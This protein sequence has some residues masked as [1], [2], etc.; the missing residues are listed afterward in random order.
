MGDPSDEMWWRAPKGQAHDWCF[1]QVRR[2]EMLQSDIYERFHKLEVLYDPL[3][4]LVTDS[5]QNRRGAVQENAIATNVDTIAATIATA[6]VDARFG[7]EGADWQ[8]QRRAIHLQ[9]YTEELKIKLEVLRYCRGGFKEGAKKGNGLV[10]VEEMFGAPH[11]RQVMVEN[12][13]IDMWET[14]DN[15]PAT[16]MHEW[17]SCD[18]DE[19]VARFPK[20]EQEIY[21]ARSMRQSWRIDGRYTPMY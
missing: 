10:K 18:A 13:V 9:W 3:T 7:T 16:H 19:L 1:R 21:K 4:P 12:I 17:V 5:P 8:Q 20:Y 2:M 15:K 11:V 14:R 6:D